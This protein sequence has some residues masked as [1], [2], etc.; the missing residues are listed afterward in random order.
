M[1]CLLLLEIQD[2]TVGEVD[3][4]NHLVRIK[5]MG[6]SELDPS[7]TYWY[8]KSDLEKFFVVVEN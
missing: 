7:E 5:D 8:S 6:M 4:G 2:F 3:F 1:I